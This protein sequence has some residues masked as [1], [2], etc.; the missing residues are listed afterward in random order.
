MRRGNREWKGGGGDRQVRVKQEL[1]L[2][3][4]EAGQE[5][6]KR[7]LKLKRLKQEASAARYRDKVTPSMFLN[8]NQQKTPSQ[9]A[10]SG[11]LDPKI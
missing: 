7:E 1:V 10:T 9:K 2:G 8:E 11:S 6:P 4:Q 3:R 5:G